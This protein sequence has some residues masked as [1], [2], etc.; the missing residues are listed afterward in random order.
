M[1]S[2]LNSKSTQE[3]ENIFIPKIK[4]SLREVELCH[5]CGG[6]WRYWC[7]RS[8]HQKI[9]QFAIPFLIPDLQVYRMTGK[10]VY[11]RSEKLQE[12]FCL[13]PSKFQKVVMGCGIEPGGGLANQWWIKTSVGGSS[14]L[15]WLGSKYGEYKPKK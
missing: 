9:K 11:V 6:N 5:Q 14:T 10:W 8:G 13:S 7:S 3:C 2:K 12:T 1:E 15:E 4:G